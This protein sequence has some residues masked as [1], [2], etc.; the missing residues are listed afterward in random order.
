MK[1]IFLLLV[2]AFC[3]STVQAQDEP[4]KG[5]EGQLILPETGDIG[6][7]FN[8]IPFFNWFGNSFNNSTNN[9]YASRDKFF[10]VLGNNVVMGKYMLTEKT[11]ARVHFGINTNA[12]SFTEFVQDDASNDPD[13]RVADVVAGSDGRYTVA[14][15]YEMRRG[16]RRIQGYYGADLVLNFNISNESFT[17]GNGFTGSNIVPSSTNFGGNINNAGGQRQLTSGGQTTF[18]IGVRPFIGVEYFV[19]PKLSIGAEFGWGIVYSTTFQSTEVWES[20]DAASGEIVID[21]E[22]QGAASSF[23]LGL[24]NMNGAVFMSFYF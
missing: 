19:A 22:K 4:L 3:M 5:K 20:F 21:N 17:Y 2:C 15:G 9:T 7:G 1:K 6:L 23:S 18:G 8:V 16:K 11:A 14:L 13:M 10:S 12:Y 24:D